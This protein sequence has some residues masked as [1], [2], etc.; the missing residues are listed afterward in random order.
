MNFTQLDIQGAWLVESCVFEDVRGSF[1]EWFNQTEM[2][3]KTGVSFSPQQG[4]MSTSKQNTIRG[5]HYSLA[6][7]GQAKFIRCLSG[8]ILDVIVDLRPESQTFKQHK[9]IRLNA[10]SA[11][12]LL[13]DIGLGHAFKA[14][15]SNTIVAYLLSS[16]YNPSVELGIDPF[17][18]D[19]NIDWELP[20]SQAVLSEK[21]SHA[22]S[23]ANAI[24]SNLLP[25][26][27]GK[28][29]LS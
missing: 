11:Q 17:D 25:G 14:E 5:I 22:S 1:H 6:S 19:L 12:S 18:F 16:P 8:S 27:N 20:K 2:F 4:N 28:V 10:N 7:E 15:S 13:I 29:N 23:L 24:K 9:S 21:D 26:M 3:T